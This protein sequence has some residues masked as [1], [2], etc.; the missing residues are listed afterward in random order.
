MPASDLLRRS[1]PY[2]YE[3]VYYFFYGTLMKPEILKGV[4]GLETKPVLRPAKVQGYELSHW[5][6]YRALID[7]E[8]NNEVSGCAYMVRPVDEEHKLAYY[9]TSAYRLVPCK[10]HFTD[11]EGEPVAGRI[12][13]YAGDAR[14]LK[15]GCFDRSLW[16]LQMGV[17]LPPKWNRAGVSD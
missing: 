12:F 1:K 10:V 9:E 14:A 16:E 15:Q 6:Q 2:T 7:G 3:P 4:L 8:P 11:R 13:I 5:G 17:Q